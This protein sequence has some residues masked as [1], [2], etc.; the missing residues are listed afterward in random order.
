MS[1]RR[2]YASTPPVVLLNRRLPSFEDMK[3]YDNGYRGQDWETDHEAPSRGRYK[4]RDGVRVYEGGFIEV[5]PY[6]Y[7][8]PEKRGRLANT[9]GLQFL[10]PKECVG[11][12][13]F[14]PDGVPVSRSALGNSTLLLDKQ[15]MRAYAFDVA[16]S[17]TP[18]WQDNPCS[19]EKN[20]ISFAAPDAVPV[21]HATILADVPDLKRV[22]EVMRENKEFFKAC[23]TTARLMGTAAAPAGSYEPVEAWLRAR[24][25]GDEPDLLTPGP[26]EMVNIGRRLI[27]LE[28]KGLQALL[29]ELSTTK[30]RFPYLKMVVVGGGNG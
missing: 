24:L 25:R 18:S 13:F 16:W 28:D 10:P 8:S 20:G 19:R 6:L 3:Q 1:R 22:K 17:A 5:E 12:K 11:L 29:T 23:A 21:A 27:G 4:Q 14:S 9:Y 7:R 30:Q 15:T 2:S 26:D